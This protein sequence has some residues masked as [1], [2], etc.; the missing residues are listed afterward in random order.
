M[1]N[2]IAPVSTK[3]TCFAASATDRP[4]LCGQCHKARPMVT[5]GDY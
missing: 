3:K 4:M 5:C 2:L 1:L